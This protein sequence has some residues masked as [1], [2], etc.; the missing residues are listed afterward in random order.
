MSDRKRILIVG[1]VAGGATA[2]ARLRRLDEDAE[3]V[4]FE[5]GEHISFAN[6][7]LPYHI[8]GT[9]PDRQRLLVQTPEG[10]RRRY[11]VD[12]CVASEVTAIDREKREVEVLERRTGRTYREPYDALVL[13]PGAE[14]VRPPIPGVESKLVFTLR[15]LADMDAI[16]AVLKE[17]DPERAVVVGGGYVGLE[18]TEALRQRGLA[19]TLVELTW[20]VMPPADPEMAALLHQELRA[21]G[22]DLRLGTSV[23]GFSERDGALD[24]RLSTGETV[25]C[26]LAVLA[27]GVRPETRL[28]RDAGL[29]LG[30][31]GGILVDE[32]MCTSDP[33]I[34]AVGDAVEVHEFVHG[35][36]SLIPLAGPANR[37]ARIAADNLL[38]RHV[39]YHC[40]Q[41]TAICKV[42]GLTIGMTGLSEKALVRAGRPFEKVYV[43]P[44]SHAGYYPGASPISLKLLFDPGDGRIL[45]AQAVGAKG[46]DKRIDVLAMALRGGLTV[47]DLEEAELSYAPPYGSAKDVVNYAGFVAANALRGDVKLC[48]AA[49]VVAPRPDQALLDVRTPAEVA[50]GTIPG[51]ITIPLDELRER[52][53]E[54]PRDK[55]VLVFCQVGMRGY[56]ACRLLSQRGFNCRN[57][58]GGYRTYQMA[59][60]EAGSGAVRHVPAHALAGALPTAP[61]SASPEMTDDTGA[62][63][64]MTDHTPSALKVVKEVDA[65]GLQCPG[66]IQR[67]KNALDAVAVGEAVRITATDPGFAADLPAWC[68]ATGHEAR[69][70]ARRDGSIQATVVK[71]GKRGHSSFPAEGGP[72][73]VAQKRGV[74]PLS[75]ALEPGTTI[76]VFSNDLD[77]ALAAFIIAN[78]A[79]SMGHQVTLFFTFW[80]LNILRRDGRVK[81]QKTLIERMFG[82]MMPRGPRRLALSKMH[83]AGMGK[84]M[85]EG[86]MR[87]KH[88]ASLPDLIASAQAAGVQLVACNMSMDLMGIKPEEL[89]DGVSLGGVATYL[90][91]AGAGRVN[92][93]I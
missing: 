32:H 53:A 41:G 17:R 72:E 23:T 13:S 14:P 66:P 10:M 22:I 55:E 12:V 80:G 86:I 73:G 26:G 83:M 35:G 16:N 70:V 61:P 4:L 5:R 9:I 64:A 45:G 88:V 11:R 37:Q 79:A 76:V 92:L 34:F 77:R 2:A 60:A 52:L 65:T 81:V 19:V 71:V 33:R 46:V 75:D 50:A 38:G 43:H 59:T 39:D 91:R 28:A 6:C 25:S 51:S 7:G 93:F 84:R 3:I 74:S 47:Y 68:H 1:G 82:L 27:V 78:G 49:D 67:L 24:V 87:R 18:M 8:G 30:Q 62:H 54:L 63:S 48:H 31:T 36:A 15:S 21:N 90:D 56:V 57:L 44:A 20:Q 29:T 89:I 58:T 40:T 85:I 69:E 42:F